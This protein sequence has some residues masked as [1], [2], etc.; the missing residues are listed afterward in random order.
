MR[1]AAAAGATMVNDVSALRSDPDALPAVRETGAAVVLMHIR[2]QP[3]TMQD[4]PRYDDVLL[5]VYDH[6]AARVEACVAVGIPRGRIAVD[7]GIGFGKTLAHNV[8][9]MRSLALFHGLGCAVLLGAS[10]KSSL[11]R[12]AGAARDDDRLPASLA[13]VLTG[14]RQG[15]QMFR[16]HDVGATRQALAVWRATAE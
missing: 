15:V 4:D 13:A 14:R 16:V 6:L 11:G 9:L 1:E 5:D 12:L 10:R 2:G 7:P 3:A 8:R